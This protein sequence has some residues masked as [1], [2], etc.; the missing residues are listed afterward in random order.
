MQFIDWR[1][2]INRREMF[3]SLFH[4]WHSFYGV[5]FIIFQPMNSIEKAHISSE[6]LMEVN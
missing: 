6:M 1:P 2:L 4:P 5:I 3:D